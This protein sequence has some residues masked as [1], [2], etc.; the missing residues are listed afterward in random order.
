MNVNHIASES[1]KERQKKALDAYAEY[2]KS[3]DLYNDN[4]GNCRRVKEEFQKRITPNTLSVN[5][6]FTGQQY[7]A[8]L[9]NGF[10]TVGRT[11]PMDLVIRGKPGLYDSILRNLVCQ[12]AVAMFIKS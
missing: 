8:R 1:D 6:I 11:V 12:L 4:D 2:D 5:V 10:I 3:F 7:E 9:S